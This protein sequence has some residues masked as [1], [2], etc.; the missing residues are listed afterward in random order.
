[1][2]SQKTKAFFLA[3]SFSYEKVSSKTNDIPQGA[4]TFLKL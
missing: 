3:H 2:T 1:M 4:I